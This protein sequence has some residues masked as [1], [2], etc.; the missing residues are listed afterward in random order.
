MRSHDEKRSGL[1]RRRHALL[2]L[3]PQGIER[4]W[5]FD[6]RAG[7]LGEDAIYGFDTTPSEDDW[8]TFFN[9]HIR[10]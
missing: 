10:E 3:A 5:A 4:R 7:T 1:E 2:S 6:Q 9:I 8:E